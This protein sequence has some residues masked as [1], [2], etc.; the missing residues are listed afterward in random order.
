MDEFQSA[1]IINKLAKTHHF[2]TGKL[3]HY[4]RDFT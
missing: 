1:F 2:K 3:I 4:K